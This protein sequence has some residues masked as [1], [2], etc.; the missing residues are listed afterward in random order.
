VVV[1]ASLLAVLL[2][3]QLVI[4]TLRGRETPA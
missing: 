2:F 3:W 4:R 1:G